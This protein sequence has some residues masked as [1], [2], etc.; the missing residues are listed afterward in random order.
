MRN[1]KIRKAQQGKRYRRS[2]AAQELPNVN[3]KLILTILLVLCLAVLKFMPENGLQTTVHS[4]LGTTTDIKALYHDLKQVISAH[5]LGNPVF[6]TPLEGE[7]TS[8]YGERV[9]PVTGEQALH[10][11]IDIDAPEGTTVVAPLAGTVEEVKE[12]AA[13][14]K[15]MLIT[16]E[17]GYTTFYAHLQEIKREPGTSVQQGEEIALS[18][19]TGVSTGPHLHFELR[20]D[21]AAV[22]PAGYLLK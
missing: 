20:K 22:D 4:M 21:G 11:G 14:G 7:I 6:H 18:G 12:D 13:Y 8:S 1:E 2:S 16:H 10:T 15:C 19:N 9:H 3:L 5:T 17:N